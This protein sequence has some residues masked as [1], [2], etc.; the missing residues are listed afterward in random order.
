M[1]GRNGE[2]K[3]MLPN[4]V[5]KEHKKENKNGKKRK[6]NEEKEEI[7]ENYKKGERNKR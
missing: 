5:K 6:R 4:N 1:K 7:T 2:K 3:I